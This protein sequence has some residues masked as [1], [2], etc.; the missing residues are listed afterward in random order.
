MMSLDTQM[1]KRAP[2]A[3]L[4]WSAML[5]GFGQLYNRDFTV[6]AV[7]I[8]LEFGTNIF[9]NL[10]YAIIHSFNFSPQDSE[11]TGVNLQWMLFYPGIW[12]YSM[13]QACNKAWEIN[14]AIEGNGDVRTRFTGLFIGL[15]ICMQL[16]VIWP[17][18]HS[19][20][21]T[22]L[23]FGFFGAVLGNLCERY[24][25]TGKA[26]HTFDGSRHGKEAYRLNAAA[27][28]AESPDAI[29][30]TAS[31]GRII[32]ANSAACDLFGMSREELLDP[33]ARVADPADSRLE[34]VFE[35][36]SRHGVATAKLRFI[37][38]DRTM[39]IGKVISSLVR[40]KAGEAY[41]GMMI[42]DIADGKAEEA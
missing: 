10:N 11:L 18:L 25:S 34:T 26:G 6:A 36:C 41:A 37:R 17:V 9:A 31:D 8:V 5:P 24:W 15:T 29:L 42:R 30:F 4:L 27:I 20:V 38:K 19:Q 28:F 32:D 23:V 3:A 7:L 35:I 39:F 14:G 13:W 2:Y 1:Q 22:G 12:S 33:D 16:G 21:L 40:M